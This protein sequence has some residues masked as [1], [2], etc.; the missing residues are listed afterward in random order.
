MWLARDRDDAGRD[1][2]NDRFPATRRPILCQ[3]SRRFRSG[4]FS[5]DFRSSATAVVPRTAA[6]ERG[7]E[8]TI[9]RTIPVRA[10]TGLEGVAGEKATSLALSG[11]LV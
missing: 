2:R 11:S 9:A 6:A 10:V 8:S 4:V 7:A 1:L 3:L 5:V